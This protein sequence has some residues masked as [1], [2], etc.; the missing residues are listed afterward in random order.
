MFN[1]KLDNNTVL[2]ML[3][4][5]LKYWT[6][7]ETTTNLFEKMYENYIDNDLFEGCEFNPMIIVDN[8]YVNWCHIVTASEYPALVTLYK[9]GEYDISCEGLGYSFIEAADDEDDPQTFLVRY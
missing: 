4:D 9:A 2:E 3:M 7:D 1:V 6:D 8:D 5:R